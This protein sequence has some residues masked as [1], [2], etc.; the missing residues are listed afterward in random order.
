MEIWGGIECTIN[1]VGDQYFDQ[2]VYQRHY[3]RTGDLQLL[4]DL[5]IKKL[6]YPILWEK[7]LSAPSQD[8][9]WDFTSSQVEF[10]RKQNV[11]VIAGL[12]HHGSGPVYVNILDETFAEGLGEYA[13]KVAARFPWISYYTPVNEPLTTARFCGLYGLWYPHKHDDVHFLR[14]LYNECKATALAMKAIR[15]INPRA[16]LVHTED[17]GK[18]HATPLLQY[19]ADFEN[20]RKWIGLDLLC[21]RVNSSHDLY[22]YLIKH[23]ISED[24][25]QYFIDNPCEPDILGFNHYITSERYLDENLTVYPPHTHGQNGKH[26]YADVEA[27]RSA[28]AVLAGPK[29]LLSEAWTRY[30]L[31]IA[32][33]EA[34]L[35][36]GR[37]DQ[38]RWLNHIHEAATELSSEGVDF[39][40]LTVWSLFGAY[41]WDRLL[42]TKERNYESG[43][44]DV[45][46]GEARPTQIARMV[47]ALAKDG[48]FQHPVLAQQGWWAR[49][50][51]ILYPTAG[52]AHIIKSPSDNPMLIIGGDTILGKALVRVCNDRNINYV[53]LS[54]RQLNFTVMEDIER[55]IN[56]YKPWAIVNAADYFQVEDAETDAENCFLSNTIGPVN[57]AVCANKFGIQLLIFSSDQVFDGKKN[58]EYT[59]SDRVN[60]LNLFGLSKARAED[61]VLKAC[62]GALIIRSSEFFSDL[63]DDSAMSRLVAAL[64]RRERVDVA[65]DVFI[66]PTLA[67]DLINGSLDLLIDGENHIWHVAN[68][69]TISWADLAHDLAKRAGYSA[70]L[71]IRKPY[72]EF[73]F[74]AVRPSYSGLTSSRGIFLPTLDD[75]LDRYVKKAG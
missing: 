27:V 17:I 21:G 23:G 25:L 6:R 10:L 20:K 37:E 22:K 3:S 28:D 19:Q 71:L 63:S 68:Q 1:R 72:A 26:H 15:K 46:T 31:P 41:G 62:P 18:T 45:R 4:A 64:S 65:D 52:S 51:R 66:S 61:E 70:S 57:L 32:I 35:H 11:D 30:K 69:G 39:R 47:A 29:A 34:H 74:N 42:T 73:N 53:S 49:P 55:A 59:E 38:L 2:L 13:G 54:R 40:G 14:I 36:C 44:F 58:S 8:I 60:P 33:T 24:E 43:A 7:H 9:D 75:A 48:K 50:D 67:A 12:V 16:K 56:Q 5:G